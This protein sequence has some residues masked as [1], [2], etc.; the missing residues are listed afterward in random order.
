MKPIQA[1]KFRV[2]TQ[3]EVPLNFSKR[4]E[5]IAAC[6]DP[7]QVIAD[8]GTD[9][10]Y[11]PQLLL[12]E[13]K[14]QKAILTDVNEGPLNNAKNTFSADSPVEFRL[15][16]GLEPI[17]KGEVDACVIAGMGG[18]LIRSILEHDPEKTLSMS[19]LVLQPMTEQGILRLWLMSNGFEILYDAYVYERGKIYEIIKVAP[20]EANCILGKS[21]DVFSVPTDDLEFGYRI[22]ARSI[23]AYQIFLEL[24]F[25]K[26]NAI[27]QNTKSADYYEQAENALLKLQTI[28]KI[29]RQLET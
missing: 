5:G 23:E 12:A 19:F 7:I 29:K 24:R 6:I 1:I 14:T 28:E 8:I 3:L 16:N 2:E 13:H 17:F 27:Y 9:H 20:H 21:D 18:E 15:G 26:Y 11:L 25:K 10:G 4:I 22:L